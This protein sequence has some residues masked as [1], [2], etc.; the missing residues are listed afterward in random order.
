L[1]HLTQFSTL[2]TR[3]QKWLGYIQNRVK[4][5]KQVI[6]Y[7]STGGIGGAV[8]VIFRS[9]SLSRGKVRNM[10]HLVPPIARIFLG[11]ARW[12]SFRHF[13]KQFF[14]H[15][16]KYEICATLRHLAPPAPPVIFALYLS[17]QFA[18]VRHPT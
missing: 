3:K 11:G 15:V 2:L 13:S 14:S 7:F 16:E 6:A 9:S 18:Q 1:T 5:V 17:F 12:R 8:F 10:R 4:Y